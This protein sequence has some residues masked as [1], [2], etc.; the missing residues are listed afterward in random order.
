NI[1]ATNEGDDRVFHLSFDLTLPP[2]QVDLTPL[3]ASNAAVVASLVVAGAADQPPVSV[4]DHAEPI[5]PT[6]SFVIGVDT[7]NP[8]A[9]I[10]AAPLTLDGTTAVPTSNW[11]AITGIATQLLASSGEVVLRLGRDGL[12]ALGAA[13]DAILGPAG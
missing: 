6:E 5:R 2:L 10:D 9:G 13:W 4:E 3:Q 11:H 7:H 8:V 1:Y 12:E